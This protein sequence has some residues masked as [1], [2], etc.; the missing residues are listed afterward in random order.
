MADQVQGVPAPPTP[1]GPAAPQAPWQPA[2]QMVHLNWSPIKPKFSGKPDEDAEAHLLL[3]KDWMNSHH[4]LDGV[5]VQTFCLT[6]SGET[7]LWSESLEPINI[8]WQF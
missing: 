2:P 3:T 8:G 7:R 5:K 6:L 1:A 4:F